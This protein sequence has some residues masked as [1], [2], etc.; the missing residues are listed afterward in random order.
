[1]FTAITL[2]VLSKITFAERKEKILLT[3][4][5]IFL[6]LALDVGVIRLVW[7]R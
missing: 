4:V 5:C 6:S 1:M 7:Q 2:W 3:R